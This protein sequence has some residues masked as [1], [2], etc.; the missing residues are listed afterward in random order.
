VGRKA[1]REQITH[2]SDAD[3]CNATRPKLDILPRLCEKERSRDGERN[4][5]RE[6][7]TFVLRDLQYGWGKLFSRKAL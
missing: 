7:A 6:P 5:R 2:A 3:E 1:L 4:Q